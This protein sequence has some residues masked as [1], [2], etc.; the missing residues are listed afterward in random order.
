MI[1]WKD[2]NK[3][4]VNEFSQTANVSEFTFFVNT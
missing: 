1:I 4:Y 2:V 3:G